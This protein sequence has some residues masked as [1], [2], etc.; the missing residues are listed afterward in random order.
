M[1]IELDL[2][3]PSLPNVVE[4]GEHD[5]EVGVNGLVVLAG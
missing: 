1:I 3:V 5:A 4:P 2:V